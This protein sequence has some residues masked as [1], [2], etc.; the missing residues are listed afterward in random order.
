MIKRIIALL[1]LGGISFAFL[2]P[3]ETAIGATTS[4]GIVGFEITAPTT[5]KVNE[6]ID[7][8]VRAIDKDKK[9]VTG[10][11][12]SIIFVS[13]NMGDTVPS[14]G[15]A[16]PFTAEDAGQKKFSK[17]VIFKSP[18]KQTIYVSDVSDDISGEATISVEAGSS[19]STGSS[20]QITIITPENNAKVASDVVMVSGNARKNSKINLALNGQDIGST[21]TDA[22]GLFTKTLT[23][24]TQAK[25]ILVASLVDANGTVIGK[26]GEITFEK[27]AQSGGYYN[28][29]VSPGTSVPAS[30]KITFTIEADPGMST[31]NV[32]LD[33]AILDAKEGQPGKYSVETVAPQNPGT[34]PISVNL[35]SSL[36]Q[37]ISKTNVLSLTVTPAVSTTS[38][39]FENVKLMTE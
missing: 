32:G 11:R 20:E 16:I 10:Y 3:I 2:L 1:S 37:V 27:V 18:G 6:A 39:K 15:K 33:G 24:L 34:Y 29:T 14:P 13:A 12:G 25:N 7:V 28:T 4:G 31:A 5:A 17:G 8:T 22:N 35:A 36:G 23:G 26:S 19:T 9:T 30:S 21:V 38:P